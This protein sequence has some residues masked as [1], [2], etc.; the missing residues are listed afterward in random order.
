MET[1]PLGLSACT[2]P[3]LPHDRPQLETYSVPSPPRARPNGDV[4]ESSCTIV[5]SGGGKGG[6]GGG[7]GGVGGGG[8]CAKNAVLSPQQGAV[9]VAAVLWQRA[10]S[11]FAAGPLIFGPPSLVESPPQSVMASCQQATHN[12]TCQ[13]NMASASDLHPEGLASVL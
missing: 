12:K 3:R 7:E 10:I 5:P 1:E 8:G 4:T 2:A 6:T 11:A 13:S 9:M